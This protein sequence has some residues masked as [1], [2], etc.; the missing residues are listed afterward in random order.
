MRPRLVGVHGPNASGTLRASADGGAGCR[1]RCR[2][3]ATRWHRQLG[4]EL[5]QASLPA[6]PAWRTLRRRP[7]LPA[8]SSAS[9]TAAGATGGRTGRWFFITSSRAPGVP[10]AAPVAE[11]PGDGR[12]RP[13]PCGLVVGIADS[14]LPSRRLRALARPLAT[15]TGRS[16]LTRCGSKRDV[17]V[18]RRHSRR[19]E[20]RRQTREAPGSV[21]SSSVGSQRGSS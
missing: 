19:P 9:T 16:A 18:W 11:G 12:A 2:Q 17:G 3:R 7:R 8:G 20:G 14:V 5:A 10:R 21:R 4:N 13:S 15:A 6:S 1:H